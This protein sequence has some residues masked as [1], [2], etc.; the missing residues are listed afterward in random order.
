MHLGADEARLRT[1]AATRCCAHQGWDQARVSA[2]VEETLDEVIEPIVYD[3]ALELIQRAPGGRAAGVHRL[4][5]TGGDRGA[6]RSLPRRRRDP[7]HAQLAIDD[8]GRYTGRDEFY[9]YGPYKAVAMR[10]SPEPRASTSQASY[11][12]SDSATDLPMLEVSAIRSPST[13]TASCT[14]CAR[15]RLGD[16]NLHAPRSAT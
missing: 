7:R 1:H 6:A 13:P 4:G 5:V 15:A 10:E 14:S 12:Y 3:E 9:C 8:E 16:P 11:A 2:I